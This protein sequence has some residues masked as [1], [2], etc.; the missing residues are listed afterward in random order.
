M[1][2]G[3]LLCTYKCIYGIS[4]LSSILATMPN[5][6]RLLDSTSVPAFLLYFY[7]LSRPYVRNWTTAR[8]SLV[9]F[10]DQG[11]FP[12]EWKKV[13]ARLSYAD[14]KLCMYSSGEGPCYQRYW[15]HSSHLWTERLPHI[16]SAST[17][18]G[19][20]SIFMD[21][22]APALTIQYP[23][24]LQYP[25]ERMLKSSILGSSRLPS[26][27]NRGEIQ[28]RSSNRSVSCHPTP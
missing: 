26:R 20:H 3:N 24:S 14:G 11:N 6:L 18:R 28:G 5:C 15:L 27:S 8:L 10:D 12:R 22:K 23:L 16:P 21:L 19:F 4:C 13:M 2:D 1:P 9:L 7:S 25:R 17:R